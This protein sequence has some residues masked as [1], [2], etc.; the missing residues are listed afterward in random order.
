M[1]GPQPLHTIGAPELSASF[2]SGRL[3]PRLRLDRVSRDAPATAAGAAATAAATAAA[4]V[5]TP[6]SVSAAASGDAGFPGCTAGTPGFLPAAAGWGEKAAWRPGSASSVISTS[7]SGQR[8]GVM[9]GGGGP[10]APTPPRASR[11]SSFSF[12]GAAAPLSSIEGAP[13]PGAAL[14]LHVRQLQARRESDFFIVA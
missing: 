4:A 8:I 11:R 2:G 3:L 12:T 9:E 5:A 14:K 10:D 6:G 13:Y 1:R 7:A